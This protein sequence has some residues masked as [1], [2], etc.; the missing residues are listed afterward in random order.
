MGNE[1]PVMIYKENKI[2]SN[3]FERTFTSDV[4]SDELVWHRDKKHRI[5]EVLND[6]DWMIQFENELPKK[7]SKGE[8]L[9]ITK[10]SYHRVIKGTTDLQILVKE[11]KGMRLPIGV[12][13][14]M[15]RGKKY[16][17]KAKMK[18]PQIEDI[19][20]KGETDMETVME[21]KKFFDSK[22]QNV[23]L[24][25]SFKGEPHLDTEY[26]EYL[27]RGGEMGQKWVNKVV[28][29]YRINQK[30]VNLV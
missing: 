8:L 6:N 26:I 2:S 18:F 19:I 20:E 7:L 9:F 30:T 16:A 22:R 1:L 23:T 13:T 21:F 28:R 14:T 27:L 29:E 10:E 15:S 4:D 11:E 17:K 24:Q 25:E 3:I 5:V 12:L